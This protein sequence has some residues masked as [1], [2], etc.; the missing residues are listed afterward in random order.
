M[1]V[2]AGLAGLACALTLQA[3]AI[4]FLILE[5]SDGP[6]GRVRTD[7]V[8]GFL[9]DRGFQV[10]LTA[11]PE[12]K[13]VLDYTALNFGH[14]APGALIRY[15]GKF[16]KA[17]DPWRRPIAALSSILSPIGS[18]ADKR[19]VG[20]FRASVMKGSPEE[21]LLRPE[22]SSMTALIDFGFSPSM[23]GRFFQPLFGSIL[24]DSQLRASSRM[25]EYVFRM[26]ASGETVLPAK[27][28]GAIPAQLAAKL[29]ASSIRY[30]TRVSSVTKRAVTL[31][32]GTELRGRAVVVATEGP[33]A[34][35]L[36]PRL[37]P[38]QSR[39]AMTMYFAIDGPPPV[40]DPMVVLNGNLQL[41]IQSCC[42]PSVVCPSY[43]PAGKH[44]LSV[45]VFGQPLQEDSVVIALVRGELA[46]WFGPEAKQWKFLRLY[47]I[48][49]AHPVL[50][51]PS[52]RELSVHPDN[53]VFVC[54]DHCFFPSIQAALENGRHAGEAVEK[55]VS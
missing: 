29:P 18:F 35:R 17:M 43:A 10:Y 8:D 27:G 24:F 49:H 7:E 6:G 51:P 26:M 50:T 16:H 31:E 45:N 21:L 46:R 30:G 1:I 40:A 48:D 13:R 22:K 32:D 20:Q 2:G 44:L 54:G 41:P 28:M 19:L 3:K 42:V 38:V 9:L 39:K 52:V 47:R 4:P 33:E 37:A 53:D 15:T 23:I 34:V 14:F 55:Y 5:A 36:L 11:Y 12:G 25:L